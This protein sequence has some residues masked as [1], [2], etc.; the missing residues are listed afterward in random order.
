MR[1]LNEVNN[2]FFSRTAINIQFNIASESVKKS[3]AT[4]G[5]YKE[6]TVDILDEISRKQDMKQMYEVSNAILAWKADKT[7]VWKD[8]LVEYGREC[9]DI[10]NIFVGENAYG[11]EIIIV[12]DSVV[13]QAV[14]EHND[15]CFDLCDNHSNIENFIVYDAEEFEYLKE[16]YAEYKKVYQRVVNNANSRRT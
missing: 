16:E 1:P 7:S 2:D 10:I 3:N 11:N 15:F 12:A 4:I 13:T 5:Q 14:L 6:L 8:A 9:D